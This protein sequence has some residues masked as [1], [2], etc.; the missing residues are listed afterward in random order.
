MKLLYCSIVAS[1]KRD[2]SDEQLLLFSVRFYVVHTYV[3]SLYY[4]LA[5]RPIRLRSFLG[6]ILL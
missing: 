3:L 4:G 6:R 2:R 5:V 1:T